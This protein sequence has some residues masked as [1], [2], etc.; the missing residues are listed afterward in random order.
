MKRSTMFWIAGLFAAA[1]LCG[2]FWAKVK[3][4]LE[5]IPENSTSYTLAEHSAQA[6]KEKYHPDSDYAVSEAVYDVKDERYRVTL[7][8]PTSA[9]S[10][11]VLEFNPFGMIIR[12]S[13]EF[14]VTRRANTG[15]RI[16]NEYN[17][18]VKEV[19]TAVPYPAELSCIGSLQWQVSGGPH[20]SAHT[21]LSDE[22]ELDGLY[23]PAQFGAKAGH[24]WLHI[25]V[26]SPEMVTTDKL[27]ATMLYVR[28]TLD[29]AKLPFHTI[30]CFLGYPNG[31]KS[32]RLRLED[33]LYAD[34]YEERLINRITEH[35][36]V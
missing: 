33:F 26:D 9:D 23:D 32:K 6:Y 35:L 12:N 5:N 18:A 4:Q 11:F 10:H 3:W 1:I 34:I 19:L 22:L 7:S 25:T 20:D 29:Q 14:D 27:A 8:S 36:D 16:S 2:C 30:S 21:I 13:Y 24:I 17:T 28:K 31:T 15:R